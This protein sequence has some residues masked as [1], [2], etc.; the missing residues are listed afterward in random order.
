MMYT[1]RG[2]EPGR[3]YQLVV[4]AENEAGEGPPSQTSSLLT[5]LEECLY[6]VFFIFIVRA[7]SVA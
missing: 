4:T 1:V 3:A 6:Y 5:I 2:L 7:L